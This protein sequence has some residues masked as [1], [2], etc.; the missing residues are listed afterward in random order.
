M[1]PSG[2]VKPFHEVNSDL[3]SKL[4]KNVKSVEEFSKQMEEMKR[5]LDEITTKLAS[6]STKTLETLE[7]KLSDLEKKFISQTEDN[8]SVQLTE[9]VKLK[10]DQLRKELEKNST[11]LEEKLSK[12]DEK[13]KG[14][15]LAQNSEESQPNPKLLDELRD[16]KKY[17]EVIKAEQSQQ[18]EKDSK[19]MDDLNQT[20]VE[21]ISRMAQVK[22][23]VDENN[24]A[25]ELQMQKNTELVSTLASKVDKT[26]SV[27]TT[28]LS[29]SKEEEYRKKLT[30]E[31]NRIKTQ[32]ESVEKL[33]SK[34]DQSE[35]ELSTLSSRVSK[36]E[37]TEATEEQV[38]G[39]SDE[40]RGRLEE[41]ESK[42]DTL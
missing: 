28:Q 22:K 10:L 33:K 29:E 1:P 6:N 16:L 34:V 7:T 36:L 17:A 32:L 35:T 23:N 14:L 25:M 9:D 31:L 3:K 8:K 40:S 24:E 5:N 19:R 27:E 26:G 42:V 30:E 2:I 4:E 38:Q 37:I 41:V 20:L 18:I 39:D 11:G 12:L 13:V 15:E 21:Q